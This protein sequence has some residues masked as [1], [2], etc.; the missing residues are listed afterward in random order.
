MIRYTNMS[1]TRTTIIQYKE[2]GVSM[3]K[4]QY[5]EIEVLRNSMTVSNNI[6]E[7]LGMKV[8]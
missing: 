3:T 7:D 1:D 2:R 5:W 6:T 4:N 8:L